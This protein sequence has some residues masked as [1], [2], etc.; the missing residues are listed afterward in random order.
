M[1]A[2]S[3]RR[4]SHL[5]VST[6]S[7]VDV[8]AGVRADARAASIASRSITR[9]SASFPR[10]VDLMSKN[11]KIITH[12]DKTIKSSA[13]KGM[14]SADFV[15]LAD[16]PDFFWKHGQ[17]GASRPFE[18]LDQVPAQHRRGGLPAERGA[19]QGDRLG[20]PP[21]EQVDESQALRTAGRARHPRHVL[22][23]RGLRLPVP[24]L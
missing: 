1:R 20:V 12:D 15:P 23:Q 4:H 5:I 21:L 7:L 24:S 22:A 3:W 14:G 17:Q 11:L 10:L 6:Q 18:G 19:E 16:V 13:F 2:W 9:L 8:A